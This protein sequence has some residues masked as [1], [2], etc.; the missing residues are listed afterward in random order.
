MAENLLWPAKLKQPPRLLIDP[1]VMFN[2]DIFGKTMPLISISGRDTTRVRY[3]GSIQNEN[4]F[5]IGFMS[6]VYKCDPEYERKIVTLPFQDIS[7]EVLQYRCFGWNHSHA[8]LFSLPDKVEVKTNLKYPTA[9][10]GMP[11]RYVSSS[12]NK[13]LFKMEGECLEDGGSGPQFSSNRA[14]SGISYNMVGDAFVNNLRTDFP[15]MFR[16]FPDPSSATLAIET[17]VKVNVISATDPDGFK[18]GVVS[19]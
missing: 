15:N 13:P 18:V 1:Q 2:E 7:T 16:D 8:D 3:L 17:V 14:Y 10:M 4:S 5:M 11:S 12:D 19:S 6:D 9:V